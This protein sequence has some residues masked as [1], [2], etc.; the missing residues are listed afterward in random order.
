MPISSTLRI[1]YLTT[2]RIDG[3]QPCSLRACSRDDPECGARC[4]VLRRRLV[5]VVPGGTGPRPPGTKTWLRGARCT[6]SGGNAGD[7]SADPGAKNRHGGAPGGVRPASWDAR[8]LARRLACR[9][10]C[11]PTGAPPSTPTSLGAPPTP[12]GGE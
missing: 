5:T 12:Q 1:F 4:G 9:V 7:G 10:T 8:R 3:E 11:T 6:D 2:Y